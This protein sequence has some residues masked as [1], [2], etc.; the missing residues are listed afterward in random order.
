MDFFVAGKRSGDVVGCSVT[1]TGTFVEEVIV[2]A[3]HSKGLVGNNKRANGCRIGQRS[4]L[5]SRL[6]PVQMQLH[7]RRLLTEPS[8]TTIISPCTTALHSRMKKSTSYWMPMPM[9]SFHSA[10]QL[11]ITHTEA[12]PYC[13]NRNWHPLESPSQSQELPLTLEFKSR[14][15]AVKALAYP[16]SSSIVPYSDDSIGDSERRSHVSIFNSSEV[17]RKVG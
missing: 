12:H 8:L 3:S 7:S 17:L 9:S 2:V 16:P 4:A 14:L 11:A 15:S 1:L 5:Q 10:C 13:Y 6:V